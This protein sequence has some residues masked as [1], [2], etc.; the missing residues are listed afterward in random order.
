MNALT[1][2]SAAKDGLLTAVGSP[3]PPPRRSLL[4]RLRPVLLLGLLAAGGLGGSWWWTTARF[5]ESTDNATLAGDIAVLSPRIEGDVAEILVG[6]NQRVAAGQPL[7]RLEDRDWTA[8]LAEAEAGLAEANAAIA[9]LGEQIGQQRA[10]VTAAEAQIASA[11]AERERAATDARRA[12]ELARG[13]YASRQAQDQAVAD[14]RKAEAA[15]AAT[16]AQAAA[17]RMQLPVLEASR[18]QAEARRDQ[19]AAQVALARSS[20]DYTVIRAPFEGIVGNRA[21]Q[22]GQHVR[23]GQQLIAV[24][25]PPER[26]WVVANFKET[27]LTRMRPGQPVTVTVDAL[28]GAELHGRLDSLAP[29]TGSQFSLLPPENATGNFTKIVQRVPVRVAI[30]VQDTAKLALLRPGLSVEAE[31]DTRDDPTA[32]RGILAAAAATLRGLVE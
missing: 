25:P 22:L 18:R 9:T 6:D 1:D 21:A 27:Q 15:V 20:L 24:A 13:G 12:N 7:I 19:A 17:Q 11:Q 31:V 16:E 23:P 8:R 28:R 2:S 3:Q 5:L 10:Q 30:D 14:M 26:Q 29:A 4:R 32:P